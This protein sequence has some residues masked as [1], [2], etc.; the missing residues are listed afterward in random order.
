MGMTAG[1][2]EH[3]TLALTTAPPVVIRYNK[4]ESKMRPNPS[5]I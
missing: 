3:P 2:V 5:V 1:K 4:L